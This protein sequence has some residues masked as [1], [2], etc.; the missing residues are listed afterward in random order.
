[1]SATSPKTPTET[2]PS[3]PLDPDLRDLVARAVAEDVGG[4][5]LTTQLVV[6]GGCHGVAVVRAREDLVVSGTAVAAAVF[7]TVDPG[8]EVDILASDGTNVAKGTT[9]LRVSGSCAS[10]LTAERTALNFL[11]HL[12]GIASLA[13]SA[14]AVV[15]GTGVC[16]LDTRKT[17]PGLRRLEK[18]A[19]VAGGVSP[20]RG[21]LDDGIL[22]K[23]NHVACCQ[24]PADAV[25]RAHA[26]R[27]TS[28]PIIIEIDT[29]DDLEDVIAAGANIVLL[30]NF[31]VD[32]VRAAA[33]QAQQRVVLE[34]SGGIT[35]TSL[36]A[37][38]EAGVDR[39]SLGF[40]THSVPA[41]NLALDLEVMERAGEH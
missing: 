31:S 28:W 2:R 40:L 25:R 6:D 36:R 33:R 26:G 4:G 3:P 7:H 34:A 35:L 29:I 30:D 22:I 20:H 38:A 23:D 5:D 19:V 15:A 27:E 17:L 1:M 24:S 8:V 41:A 18:A 11:Q 13:A 16:L 37:F 10:I 14:Q 32:E 39:I 9:V 12:C 21:G